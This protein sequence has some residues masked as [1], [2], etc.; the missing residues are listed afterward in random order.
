MSNK[1]SVLYRD[2]SDGKI[3]FL[4]DIHIHLP[5]FASAPE[6]YVKA[7]FGNGIESAE[8]MHDLVQWY[9]DQG[10]RVVLN[11]DILDTLSTNGINNLLN[12]GGGPYLDEFLNIIGDLKDWISRGDVVYVLGNHD[13]PELLDRL[14][15]Q[16]TDVLNLRTSQGELTVIHGHE[17]HDIQKAV[18][19]GQD[20]PVTLMARKGNRA[21]QV[22]ARIY[23]LLT[24]I[25][26]RPFRES[27]RNDVLKK[28]AEHYGNSI[29]GHIHGR[30]KIYRS[31]AGTVYSIP[32]TFDGDSGRESIRVLEIT[33]TGP[34][35]VE[36]DHSESGFAYRKIIPVFNP[37]VK[38]AR[39]DPSQMAPVVSLRQYG[40]CP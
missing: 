4:S 18:G 34:R 13:D 15:I 5:E 12:N 3:A 9:L 37:C 36:L 14:G 29:I 31:D 40:T 20:G 27:A 26:E 23:G 25:L 11:G 24:L 38:E 33:E 10:Y 1:P 39:G 21:F 32:K 2:Y 6:K 16:Y 28:T 8:K 35:Y 19:L 30:G 17:F 22:L 7:P